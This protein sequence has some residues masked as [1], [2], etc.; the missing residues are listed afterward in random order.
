MSVNSFLHPV[1]QLR[2][3]TYKPE[4]VKEALEVA[5]QRAN[6][7]TDTLLAVQ[8]ADRCYENVVQALQDSTDELELISDVVGHLAHVIGEGWEDQEQLVSEKTS[9]F[10]THRGLREDLYGAIKDVQ[11]NPQSKKLS[12]PKKRLLKETIIYF[13]RNGVSAPVATKDRIKEIKAELSRL[14]TQFGQNVVKATDAA[15][16]L[17]DDAEQLSG[18]DEEHIAAWAEAAK[19]KD[20]KGY[21]VQFSA[22][23]YQMI[24]TDC[25]NA[26]TR[27]A[28]HKISRTRAPENEAIA[29]QMLALRKE[30][31]AL[32]GYANYADY[33][34][35]QRMAK[36]G[37]RAQE[38]IDS[39]TGYYQDMMRKEGHDLQAFIR[40]T[41]NNPAYELTYTDVD[42][43]T[44]LYFANKLRA[45]QVGEDTSNLHEYFPLEHVLKEMFQTLGTLYGVTFKASSQPS[46][47]PDAQAYDMY[48]ENNAHTATVWCD[49]VAREG[50]RA[51]AW[52]H[53]VYIADRV[54]GEVH[55]PHLAFVCGNFPAPTKTKPSLLTIR[56]VETMWHEFGHF[57]HVASGR[58]ELREQNGYNSKWDFI[59]APS[60]IMENWVWEDE[61]LSR[62]AK[63]YKT[64]QSLPASTVTKLRQQRSFRAASTAMWTIHWSAV[65]LFLH[66][67]YDPASPQT[68][69]ETYRELKAPFFAAPVATYDNALTTFSHIFAGGYAAAYYG[70]KWAESIEADLFSR[71]QKEGVLNP[72]TGRAYRDEI[73]ARGDEHDPDVLIRNFLGRDSTP[74]AM[75]ARDGIIP[76]TR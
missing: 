6:E 21:F 68:L 31:A 42:G 28:M 59:E 32:L 51:G 3:G 33:T 55:E 73:L 46:Y 62:L 18:I 65:D 49:W 58:T 63:H 20:K 45:Q 35:E 8:P 17:L 7:R 11:A 30:L 12:D 16:L 57:I 26:D 41:T 10:Y 70:Y 37:K 48:D 60:Q 38:F 24:M 15:Y 29:R 27:K 74:A 53:S 40:T 23:T 72:K 76:K 14:S 67:E 54:N 47:H 9:A 1:N 25:A 56:D 13:E 66:T 22:P 52:Q 5:I 75:L 43:G 36:T 39:L 44:D 64:G 34:T 69:A 61:V 50:K 71:F 2:F 19:H 4:D